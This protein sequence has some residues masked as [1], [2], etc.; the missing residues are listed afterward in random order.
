MNT[1]QLK[2]IIECALLTAGEPLNL[3]RLRDLFQD[4]EEHPSTSDLRNV[5]LEIANDCEQRGIELQETASG[6][7]F[8]AKTE[9]VPWIKKLWQERPPRYSRALL[10]TLAIVA[11]R[12]PV[13]RAEIEEIRG[14]AVS[15]NII[16]TLLDHEWIRVIGQREVP[17]RPSL[18]ATTRQFL[19][20]FSLKTLEELPQLTELP[21]LDAA[22]QQLELTE[23]E[24]PTAIVEIDEENLVIEEQ[25]AADIAE[26]NSAIEEQQTVET[27]TEN[28]EH[29]H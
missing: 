12:Q 4:V 17:G 11:Y 25:Q 9:F 10:E 5:I 3:E 14:V 6:F 15:S 27:Q 21:D 29:V 16:K 28:A 18:F 1:E 8:R 20:H 26:E 23:Q 7:C 22:A 19:D 13:T 2:P 24:Q